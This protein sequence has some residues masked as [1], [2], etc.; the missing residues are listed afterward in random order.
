M[1]FNLNTFAIFAVLSLI[2]F[3]TFAFVVPK[4]E[5]KLL[6]LEVIAFIFM[7]VLVISWFVAMCNE[8]DNTQKRYI[9]MRSD[10]TG[11]PEYMFV[12]ES[13]DPF[14]PDEDFIYCDK[15]TIDGLSAVTKYK[16]VGGSWMLYS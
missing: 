5:Y 13:G 11:E 4:F 1:A 9:D 10:K 7:I 3:A 6:I 16:N 15:S 8:Q 2:L 12:R 14:L